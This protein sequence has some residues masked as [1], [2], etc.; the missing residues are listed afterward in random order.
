[1][2]F[3]KILAAL[4][5]L[6]A[7]LCSPVIG[8]TNMQDSSSNLDWQVLN[9]WQLP[10]SPVD[11]VHSLDGKY[12]FVL[13][14]EHNVLVYTADGKLE[15]TIPV[16]KG[17]NA[18]DIAPRAEMLYLINGEKNSFTT[19][20]VSFIREINTAG[21]P[22]RG[23]ENAP[24]TIALFTDFECPYC[25][26]I[27]PL[28]A[29]V[30]ERNP[31]NVRL[32]FKNMPLQ[33]HKFADPAARA[34]LAAEKQGKFWEFHDELFSAEKLSNKVI[35][36]IAVKLDL[37]LEQWKKDMES[38]VIRQKVHTDIQDAQK[39][40]VTGTPTI[41]INGRLLQDRSLQGFQRIIDEEL[42]KK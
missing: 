4:S 35:E 37:D 18:I 1:M 27:E 25:S 9:Q 41:F 12:V 26:K 14:S 24:V 10:Q 8:A 22:I 5:I 17:V 38:P 16:D 21:A 30:L 11:I 36:D 3:K 23:P 29:Q 20:S 31:K 7:A 32:A 39:A 19:I 13:T 6:T 42:D 34:A 28:I 33:F 40:G 15:G 2:D